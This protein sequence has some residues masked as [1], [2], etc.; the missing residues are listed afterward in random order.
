ME[1]L[2]PGQLTA[3]FT[4]KET[5]NSNLNPGTSLI[6]IRIPNQDFVR[7]LV[8]LCRSPIALTSANK[9]GLKSTLAIE[10]CHNTC[11]TLHA[12][13]EATSLCN[14]K[15]IHTLY[16][17]YSSKFCG[18]FVGIALPSLQPLFVQEFQELWQTLNIIVDG[19]RIQD[20]E[21]GGCRLGSSV[22]NFS[23][24]GHYRVLRQGRYVVTEV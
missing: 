11:M 15:L 4:R 21:H 24:E 10:V 19:G 20:P 16:S 3:V 8:R 2:F 17:V 9:S 1:N 14:E 23:S 6:G 5:L 7:E 22:L 13:T 18:W 12:N